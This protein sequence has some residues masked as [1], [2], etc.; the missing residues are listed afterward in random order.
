MQANIANG[1]GSGGGAAGGGAAGG[2]G[3]VSNEEGSIPNGTINGRPQYII[4]HG[5][6][7]SDGGAAEE[8]ADDAVDSD[9]SDFQDG[10][11]SRL[12]RFIGNEE[13]EGGDDDDDD[14]GKQGG[15]GGGGSGGGNASASAASSSLA[16]SSKRP[17]KRAKTEKDAGST[18]QQLQ[19]AAAP[20]RQRIN[21]YQPRFFGGGACIK[22]Y[23]SLCIRTSVHP[24][25]R[26]SGGTDGTDGPVASYASITAQPPS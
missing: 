19:E 10:L 23:Q 8:D 21:N 2:S 24:C 1:G 17:K 3:G 20:L 9:D 13:E 4:D 18:A 12:S 22:S 5:P 16:S 25:I 7:T 26:A 11:V 6:L 15:S 14:D